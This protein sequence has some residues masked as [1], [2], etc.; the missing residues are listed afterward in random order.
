M[1]PRAD[2]PRTARLLLGTER[3]RPARRRHDNGPPDANARG[4]GLTFTS[5]AIGN[6][7]ACGIG[8]LLGTTSN[9]AFG[10]GTVGTPMTIGLRDGVGR[11][12]PR[13]PPPARSPAYAEVSV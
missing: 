4:R 2:S 7:D 13:R 12:A 1:G 11:A 5:L 3:R 6:A 10:D 9:G 8:G